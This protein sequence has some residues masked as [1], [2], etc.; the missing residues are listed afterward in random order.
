MAEFESF[1]NPGSPTDPSRLPGEG[2]QMSFVSKWPAPPFQNTGG[3]GGGST[4]VV[5][6]QQALFVLRGFYPTSGQYEVWSGTSRNTPN[7]SGHPLTDIT[8]VAELI[9][10]A[11]Y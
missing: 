2:G 10:N 4:I 7:P 3:G 5:T 8:V 11:M 1:A 9:G 6:I